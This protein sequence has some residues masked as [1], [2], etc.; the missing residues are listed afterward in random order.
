MRPHARSCNDAPLEASLHSM[1][2]SHPNHLRGPSLP[3]SC[4]GSVAYSVTSVHGIPVHTAVGAIQI[5]QDSW[6][7]R[8]LPNAAFPP[9]RKGS[10]VVKLEI[11]Q[12]EIPR[13]VVAMCVLNLRQS[14]EIL[15]QGLRSRRNEVIKQILTNVAART[16]RCPKRSNV[17]KPLAE[18]VARGAHLSPWS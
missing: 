3:Q 2:G 15:H 14:R 1:A 4:Q 13:L 9:F 5:H 10:E 7:S 12:L 6:P 11:M 17:I 16:G 18:P 8:N